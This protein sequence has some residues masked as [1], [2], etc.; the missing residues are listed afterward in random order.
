LP[1]EEVVACASFGS[2]GRVSAAWIIRGS[3]AAGD[4]RLALRTLRAIHFSP[5]HLS[6]RAVAS[7]HVVIVGPANWSGLVF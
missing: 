2:D 7:R 1:T 4:D 5:A 3:K 6:G